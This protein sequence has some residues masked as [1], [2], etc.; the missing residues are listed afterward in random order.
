MFSPTSGPTV[1]I[2]SSSWKISL[3]AKIPVPWVLPA[4]CT[5]YKLNTPSLETSLFTST[6]SFERFR[7]YGDEFIFCNVELLQSLSN[8][9]FFCQGRD[10]NA[11]GIPPIRF[12]DLT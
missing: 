8:R 2:I 5:V 1:L 12:L 9:E 4:L 10:W 7:V 3:F 6:P 11:H